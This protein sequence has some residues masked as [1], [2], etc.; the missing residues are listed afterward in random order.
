MRIQN[1]YAVVLLAMHA[2]I[3]G[4]CSNNV[5]EIESAYESGVMGV[6]GI[7]WQL[8]EVYGTRAEPTPADEPAAHF[9]LNP[10]DHQASG[11]SGI[12][13]FSGP[14]E[15]SGMSLRFRPLAMTRRAGPE[16]LMRQESAFTQALTDARSWRAIGDRQ[17]ELLDD[18]GERL[19]TFRAR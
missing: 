5:R 18:S 10:A 6:E 16:P 7:L 17:I 3:A 19:A 14:Y 1:R 2:L 15:L 4:C 9:V 12:N 8:D 13:H 11:Y